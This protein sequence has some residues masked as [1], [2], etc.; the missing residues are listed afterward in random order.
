MSLS[1]L[2]LKFFFCVLVS[3]K[4]ISYLVGGDEIVQMFL[5]VVWYWPSASL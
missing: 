4:T 3:E 1:F 2:N 5:T